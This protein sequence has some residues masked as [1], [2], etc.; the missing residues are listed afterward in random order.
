MADDVFYV[1]DHI[2]YLALTLGLAPYTRKL[3][4][5]QQGANRYEY[6]YDKSM[7]RQCFTVAGIK[8]N[9]LNDK[10]TARLAFICSCDNLDGV[11]LLYGSNRG[12][13]RG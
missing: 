10:K 8:L 5:K 13:D 11:G 3:L 4:H 12:P 6:H 1:F 2:H 7:L 9:V